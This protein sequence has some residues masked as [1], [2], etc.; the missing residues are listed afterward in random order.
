MKDKNL[1]NA[2]LNCKCL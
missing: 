2:N 1:R